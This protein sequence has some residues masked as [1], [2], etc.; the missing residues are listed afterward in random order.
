MIENNINSLINPMLSVAD[1]GFPVEGVG[2]R[3]RSRVPTSD[4]VRSL[5]GE[6]VCQTLGNMQL[7]RLFAFTQVCDSI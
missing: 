5:F 1:S 6:N 2:W 3:P 7:V 4:A